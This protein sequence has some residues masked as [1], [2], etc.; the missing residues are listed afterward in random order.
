[1]RANLNNRLNLPD[2]QKPSPPMQRR[3]DVNEI[4]HLDVFDFLDDKVK[5]KSID[6]AIIDP[7]YNMKKAEWDKF[8]NHDDFLNFTFLWIEKLIPKLKDS[9]SLYIFNTP[10]NSAY[11][12]Q[13]LVSQRM[14]F[15]NWI[16]WDKQDGI[17]S[18]KNKFVSG[19]ETILFFTK[20]SPIFNFDEVREPYKSEDR[21]KHATKKGILKA[22]KRWY[23]NPKGRLCSEV[24][25]FSSERHKNK[26]NGKVQKM[27]HLTP[28][29][30]D[31]I[32]RMIRASSK[33]GDLILDCFMGSGTTA[34]ACQ[35]L[36][37]N[38]IGCESSKEYYALCLDNIRKNG[39]KHTYSCKSK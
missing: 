6:L 4:Y 24:W 38:F 17:S 1:M 13:F 14:T 11:I 16:V 21:I 33:E 32:E 25:H 20:G 22:G 15:K 5:N 19:S 34:I 10:F 23:P 9:S 3:E 26:K 28:K 2:R 31:M 27:P 36:K 12:L 30:V 37:R 39:L 8:K 29:P 18:P 7:P 35:N